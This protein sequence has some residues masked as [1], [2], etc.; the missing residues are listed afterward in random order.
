VNAL[1]WLGLTQPHRQRLCTAVVILDTAGLPPADRAEAVISAM[2][3]SFISS[4]I[5]PEN[6]GGACATHVENWTFGTTSFFRAALPAIQFERTARQARSCP[7]AELPI[8]L[9]EIGDGPFNQCGDQRVIDTNQLVVHDIHFPYEFGWTSSCVWLPL[10][11][12]GLP[13]DLIRAASTRLHTSP[14]YELVVNHIA[15][16]TRHADEL[17]ADPAAA[18]LGTVSVELARALLTSAA[19]DNRY[20]QD[21]LDATLLTG[22]RSYVRKHLAAADL[23]P[24]MIAAAHHISVRQ[25]YKLCANAD[26]SLHHWMTSQRLQGAREELA[27]HTSRHRSIAMIAQR[28]GF[29]NPTHFTRRFRANYGITPREWR[30]VAGH[31]Q[32]AASPERSA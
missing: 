29:S 28:W 14:V 16:L 10:D 4:H 30:R 13:E 9:S 24:E 5:S 25:L 26:F 2:R 19:P 7:P 21:A 17:S 20:R 15:M 27:G 31:D 6:P 11:E 12:L 18:G 8:A 1:K 22:I 32:L 23:T 3:D